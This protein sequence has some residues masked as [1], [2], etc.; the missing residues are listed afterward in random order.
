M[1]KL[2][3]LILALTMLCAIFAACT[4][5]PD[6]DTNA[7]TDAA[8]DTAAPTDTETQ[9]ELSDVSAFEIL[10]FLNPITRYESTFGTAEYIFEDLD[11]IDHIISAFTDEDFSIVNTTPIAGAKFETTVLYKAGELV[12]MYWK[13]SSGELRVLY[14]LIDEKVLDTLK[15]N[16]MSGS[17]I[18][19]MAQVGTERVDETDNPFN[20]MC[21]VILLASGKAI[22]VDGGFP[23]EPCAD[24]LFAALGKLGVAKNS[25]GQFM[26]EAWF[27]SH[28]HGDH[29]GIMTYFAPKYGHLVDIDYLVYNFPSNDKVAGYHGGELTFHELC[30]QYFADT[31]FVVPHAGIK[32]YFGNVVIDMLFTPDLIWSPET[33]ITH[34]NSTS[35]VYKLQGGGA[36]Y[37]CFGDAGEPTS[38][39][40]WNHY[41]SSAFKSDILQITHHGLT[42][43]GGSSGQEWTY[44]KKVY[45]ASEATYA[46]LPMHSRYKTGSER[47]GRYTVLIQWCNS[48]CQSSFVMNESD[49]HGR[50]SFDQNYYNDFCD[51]VR[52]GTNTK[53]TLYGYDGINKV[54]SET[55]LITYLGGNEYKPMITIFKLSGGSVTVTENQELYTWLA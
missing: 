1:K 30:K 50:S 2:L 52:N 27:F 23:N 24:N 44:L 12:T 40:M 47:N 28:A 53:A 25:D 31:T 4:E 13:E 36:S 49:N 29:T 32:Y 42:T 14:E 48:G 7:P 38:E 46:V 6:G 19:T 21:Y 39:A 34:Y 41:D 17:G 45:E 3:A 35:I 55:G 20:G 16:S 9:R 8:S 10:Y 18:I 5:T 43:G 37:L 11:G 26:I 22:I 33:P 15:A 54:V 51:S